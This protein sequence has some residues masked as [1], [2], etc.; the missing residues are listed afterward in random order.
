MRCS[1]L[2]DRIFT[3]VGDIFKYRIF[4]NISD[5]VN[6]GSKM[7]KSSHEAVLKVSMNTELCVVDPSRLKLEP[8][9]CFL[10]SDAKSSIFEGLPIT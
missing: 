9:L 3:N 4:A 8:T 1:W 7:S 5:L 2:E 6:D 10:S